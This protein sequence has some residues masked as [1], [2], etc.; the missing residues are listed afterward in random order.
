VITDL[1]MPVMDGFN[2]LKQL[3]RDKNLQHL[4]VLVSSASVAQLDQQMSIEAGGDDFLAKP[5]STVDL[6]NALAKHL[7]L[8]WDYEEVIT[9]V[10]PS[11][12]MIAPTPTDLQILLELAQEGR[13]KKLV[14][15][16]VQIEQRDDRYRPFMQQILQFAR[17]FQAENIEQLIQR[18]LATNNT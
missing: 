7:Q 14:E 2:L 10:S 12:E 15:V 3:R 4:K 16:A 6:F 13:L 8:T 18:Y 17:Q 11:S 5:V 1:Q 9:T